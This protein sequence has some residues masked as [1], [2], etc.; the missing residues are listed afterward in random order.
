MTGGRAGCRRQPL[1]L[2]LPPAETVALEV[3]LLEASHAFEVSDK[4]SLIVSGERAPGAV[5]SPG[6]LGDPRRAA[7]GSAL[8]ALRPSCRAPPP[9]STGKV[10]QWED[11]DPKLF[12]SQGGPAPQA[13]GDPEAAS[14]L[15]MADVYKEL[16]LCGYEYGPQFQGIHEASFEGEVHRSPLCARGRVL[17]RDGAQPGALAQWREGRCR[18]GRPGVA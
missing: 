14:R 18:C 7:P 5:A 3:R 6:Q 4:G 16:R 2:S 15:V 9:P 11:P 17:G 12:S 1:T 10:Y 8:P 13:P